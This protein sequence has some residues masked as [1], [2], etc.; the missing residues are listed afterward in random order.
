MCTSGPRISINSILPSLIKNVRHVLCYLSLQFS[1]TFAIVMCLV[2]IA[3]GYHVTNLHLV[4]GDI[5]GK[6]FTVSKLFPR[7]PFFATRSLMPERNLF[8]ASP[9]F[10]ILRPRPFVLRFNLISYLD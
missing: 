7:L 10:D 1:F 6:I 8:C 5:G 2:W 3:V 9:H 4:I